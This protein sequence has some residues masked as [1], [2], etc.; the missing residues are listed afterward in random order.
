MITFRSSTNKTADGH[1][2]VHA[3]EHGWWD[4]VPVDF[5]PQSWRPTWGGWGNN[6]FEKS[7]HRNC[8]ERSSC[9]FSLWWHQISLSNDFYRRRPGR[10]G[11]CS[12]SHCPIHQ[13][14][15]HRSS[16]QTKRCGKHRPYRRSVKTQISVV[17]ITTHGWLD[18]FLA[19]IN[20]GLQRWNRRSPGRRQTADGRD[21]FWPQSVRTAAKARSGCR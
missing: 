1:L 14:S 20:E 12:A 17:E 4:T 16:G 2:C 18:D 7:L 3:S 21:R 11:R 10:K 15:H 6:A 8:S 9:D 19:W 5:P 13:E